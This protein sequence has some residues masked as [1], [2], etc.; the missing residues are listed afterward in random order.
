MGK[1]RE[2]VFA[3]FKNTYVEHAVS[4]ICSSWSMNFFS[5]LLP[6]PQSSELLFMEF[7]CYR[8][9]LGLVNFFLKIYLFI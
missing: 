7:I 8:R 4:I 3:Y 2:G 1:I 5:H 9:E 6:F